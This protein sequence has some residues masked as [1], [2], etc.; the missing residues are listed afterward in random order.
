MIQM[1][2]S[3]FAPASLPDEHYLSYLWR[4]A[5]LSGSNSLYKGLFAMTGTKTLGLA[6]ALAPE[7]LANVLKHIPEHVDVGALMLENTPERHFKSINETE[8]GFAPIGTKVGAGFSNQ[9]LRWCAACAKE[10]ERT[11]GLT[12]WRNSH[13]DPRL[14][15]C[16]R[17]DLPLLKTCH[18]CKQ[19]KARL[20][21]LKGPPTSAICQYCASR[22]DNQLVKSLTPFQKWMELLHHLSNHGVQVNRN[23]LIIRVQAVVADESA[24][25]KLRPRKQ[26]ELPQ[27]R[28]IEAFNSTKACDHFSFGEVP[29]AALG[30]Y[31]QLRLP[32]I[33]NPDIHHSPI[34]YAL[35]GWHFLS[36]EECKVRF[37]RFSGGKAIQ[38]RP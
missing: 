38:E 8:S 30:S 7:F 15:R 12:Y 31:S 34:I 37:G 19:H 24:S 18:L 2:A 35:L 36:A 9:H 1:D 17:H 5:N 22:L 14:V 28:F 20:T 6:Q 29:Y 26:W 13:Q 27:K 16:Q 21:Q 32:Y 11:L 33:L 25:M 23:E 10:D 3:P 4:W